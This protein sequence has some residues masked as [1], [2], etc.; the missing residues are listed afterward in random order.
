MNKTPVTN[1]IHD[2]AQTFNCTPSFRGGPH[3][4]SGFR[5]FHSGGCQFLLCDGSVRFVGESIDLA[6]YRALSTIRGGEIVGEF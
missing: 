4:V 6:S 2:V 3:W 5:S 1:A